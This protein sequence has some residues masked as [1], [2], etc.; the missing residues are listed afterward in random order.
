LSA[1]SNE[2]EK[3]GSYR[4]FVEGAGVMLLLHYER[5]PECLLELPFADPATVR[6]FPHVLERGI[7]PAGRFEDFFDKR[8]EAYV[9]DKCRDDFRVGGYQRHDS[10][11]AEKSPSFKWLEK[12]EPG[13]S[14]Q[15]P[16]DVTTTLWKMAGQ[17]RPL[18]ESQMRV[19]RDLFAAQ[20]RTH[21]VAGAR[22]RFLRAS[23]RERFDRHFV[24][25]HAAFAMEQTGKRED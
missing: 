16:G 1:A 10:G 8:Y 23:R 9:W 18:D 12:E 4:D 19:C 21:P 11:L 3:F 17:S 15:V 14:S 20:A 2:E 6:G 24:R 13:Q 5:L 22:E 25:D 7:R